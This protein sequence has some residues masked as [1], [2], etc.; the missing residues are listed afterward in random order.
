MEKILGNFLQQENRDFPL[1]AETL[2]YLQQL[3]GVCGVLGNLGGDRVVLCGCE[4]DGLR[5]GSGWVFLRTRAYPEGEVLFWEGGPTDGGMYVKLEDVGVTA[6]NCSYPKAYTRRS[7]AP[8]YGDEHY[9]WGDFRDVGTL[10]DV[11]S[12]LARIRRELDVLQPVPVG[13]VVMWAGGAVPDGYVLCDGRQLRREDYPDLWGVLG[14]RFN[15]AVSAWGEAYRT[16]EGSFRVPDLRGRFVVGLHDSDGDYSALGM[17][18]GTKK[19]ALQVDE[20]PE[21]GHGFKD[22]YHAEHVNAFPGG[23]NYDVISDYN[24]GLGSGKTDRDNECYL[25]VEHDT[26]KCGAGMAHENRPPFYVMAYIIR[27]KKI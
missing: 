23:T 4:R 16:E 21:H 9:D 13:G 26:E 24:N 1:D 15:G 11:V 10:A 12:E 5:R 18:G 6:N 22:Y 3:S 19:V 20:L 8:G 14:T 7:L 25:W 17:G 2:D 27:A